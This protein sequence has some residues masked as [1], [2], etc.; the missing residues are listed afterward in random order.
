MAWPAAQLAQ[1]AIEPPPAP[2]EIK[3]EAGNKLY[4]VAH[5]EGVQI[6]NCKPT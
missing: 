4:L 5:A 3:V 1:A 6:Y 2:P